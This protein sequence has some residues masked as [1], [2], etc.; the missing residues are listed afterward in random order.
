MTKKSEVDAKIF[1]Q[2]KGEKAA[3]ELKTGDAGVA[4]IGLRA[5][6]GPHREKG[7]SRRCANA[8]N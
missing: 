3:L 2:C 5:V 1:F 6:P 7:R 8:S 4:H